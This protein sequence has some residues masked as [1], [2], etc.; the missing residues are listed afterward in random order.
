MK[1]TGNAFRSIELWV[2]QTTKKYMDGEVVYFFY[3]SV[4]F[5]LGPLESLSVTR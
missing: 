2:L 5:S 3:I 1:T 4:T